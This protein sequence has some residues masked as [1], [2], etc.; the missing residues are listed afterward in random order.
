MNK[1]SIVKSLIWRFFEK[2][3]SQLVTS[4]VSIVLARILNPSDY[5]T[6][7]IVTVIISLLSVFVD[8]GFG[9][10]LIQKKDA[11]EFDFFDS[12]YF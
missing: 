4:F 5:G 1:T 6:L 9:I 7:A 2:C 3:G 11:D 10:A 12:I 8:S